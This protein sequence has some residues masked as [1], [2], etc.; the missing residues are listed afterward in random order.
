MF[1]EVSDLRDVYL[2]EI[3]DIYQESFPLN[4]QQPVS[5]WIKFLLEK[6]EGGAQDRH[7]LAL[8]AE[9]KIAGFAFYEKVVPLSVGYLSYLATRKDLRSSGLGAKLYQEI[10]ERIFSEGCSALVFEV[11][12]PEVGELSSRRIAWY[13]RNGAKLLK[14]IR[15]IQDLGWQP[16]V[17]MDIML[18]PK[19]NLEADTAFS[20][21]KSIFG[22]NVQ[23]N[24]TLGIE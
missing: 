17:E 14:G 11:E 12:K 24:G 10:L 13:R 1:H 23:Q 4:E 22:Q 3:F 15:Y 20:I 5:W 9:E 16:P 7:L 6:S 19:G 2:P 18:H 21:V 8:I